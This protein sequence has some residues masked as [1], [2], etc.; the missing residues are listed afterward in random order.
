MTKLKGYLDRLRENLVTLDEQIENARKMSKVKT[1]GDKAVALQYVKTLRDLVE[2]RSKT[3]LEIKA[4]LLGREE[5]GSVN[6]PPDVYNGNN[7]VEFERAFKTFMAPWTR[8]DLKLKCAD[9]GLES[10]E[11]ST[12][13]IQHKFDPDD[14]FDLCIGCYEKRKDP[15]PTSEGRE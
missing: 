3:L 13:Q 7:E 6:E 12:R 4:H 11:V 1:K 9:C 5:T 14:Y 8:E 2:L 10:E 15:Q